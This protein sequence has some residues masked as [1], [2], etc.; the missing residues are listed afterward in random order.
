MSEFIMPKSN[1]GEGDGDGDDDGDHDDAASDS[2]EEVALLILP[3]FSLMPLC[4]SL[5]APPL[6]LP[7]Q[8]VNEN[9]LLCRRQGH[10]HLLSASTESV[11][12]GCD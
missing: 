2:R 8:I 1:D 12:N 7:E 5:I 4:S 10:S 11:S 3:F 6:F 9:F